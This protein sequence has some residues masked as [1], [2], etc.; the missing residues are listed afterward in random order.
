[1]VNCGVP[2]THYATVRILLE[3]YDTDGDGVITDSE[4][5][6]AIL[7]YLDGIITQSEVSHILDCY[8]NYSGV[9]NDYCAE[10]CP[11]PTCDFTIT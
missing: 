8:D 2:T 11:P 7:D 1:M 9:I 5:P 6:S 10:L 4:A 3:H